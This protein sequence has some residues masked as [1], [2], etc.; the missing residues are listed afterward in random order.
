MKLLSRFL[1]SLGMG[2]H[3]HVLPQIP[4]DILR[5]EMIPAHERVNCDLMLRRIGSWDPA[6]VVGTRAKLQTQQTLLDALALRRLL[7][8][9]F[10]D[11]SR[12]RLRIFRTSNG[13][14]RELVLVGNIEA[15]VG[16]MARGSSPEIQAKVCGFSFALADGI[17]RDM[18]AER[19][20]RAC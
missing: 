19:L 4:M 13:G 11:I 10:P 15:N 20:S 6:A 12:A 17:L 9:N 18:T 8:R 14:A 16:D 1:E 3:S 2:K 7:F 5:F